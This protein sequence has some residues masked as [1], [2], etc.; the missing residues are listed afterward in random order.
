M[1][2]LL[3]ITIQEEEKA[4]VGGYAFFVLV[5]RHMRICY[6]FECGTIV[7]QGVLASIL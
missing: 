2:N 1:Y 7:L 4:Y 3:K 5:E 6:D